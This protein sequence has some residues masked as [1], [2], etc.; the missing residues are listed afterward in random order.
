MMM[1]KEREKT[2]RVWNYPIVEIFIK[3][4]SAPV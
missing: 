1:G 4:F 2:Y 3:K